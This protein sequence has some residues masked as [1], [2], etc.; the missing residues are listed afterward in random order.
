MNKQGTLVALLGPT[1]SGK[2]S[3]SLDLAEWLQTEIVSC[4]SRQFFQELK[5]GAAP[6]SAEELQKIPHHFIQHLSISSDY[7]AGRYE[8]DAIPVIEDVIARKGT[9]VL[10]GGSGMYAR[11]IFH[12]FDDLPKASPGIRDE[13]IKEV[14]ENG[15][16]NLQRELKKRDPETYERIDLQNPQR[17][18]RALE[19]IRSTGRPYSEMRKGEPRKRTFGI[20]K[21]G[22]KLD[23]AILY[24]RINQRVDQMIQDGLIEEAREL[25]PFRDH[26]AL[27]TVGYRELFD[28]F[29]GLVS[30]EEAIEKIKKNT[31]N[32]AKRQMTWFKREPGIQW[33]EPKDREQIIEFIAKRLDDEN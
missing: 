16:E 18:I 5:I 15:L 17:M 33:F 9:A 29:Q 32:F 14:N 7:N 23:R 12:G 2:T 19:I 6:P 3:L 26:N 31:R 13:L 24:D 30:R 11:A 8:Q 10:V 28:Y 4:D 27:Q 1:A 21:L 20:V 25:F 22:L